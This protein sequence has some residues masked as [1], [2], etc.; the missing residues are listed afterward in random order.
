M[1]KSLKDV[2]WKEFK[3]SKLCKIYH[4]KRLTKS[5]R[6]AGKTPL[7]TASEN[8]QGVSDFICNNKLEKYQNIITID[9]FGHAFYHN[10]IC[11]GD[12]NIYFFENKNLSPFVMKF[13]TTCINQNSLKY[14]YGKQFRQGNADRDLVMLP[15]TSVGEPDYEFME[16]YIKEREKK[17]KEQYKD[18]IQ[19]R[20]AKLQ[21]KVETKK[22]WKE[23]KLKEI[24]DIEKGNQNKM[25]SL[26][27]GDIPLVSAKKFDNGYKNFVKPNNKKIFHGNCIS[28]NNDGDGGAGI[29]YY[30]PYK[31]LLDT[32]C[33]ALTSKIK[34]DK[35]AQLFL[36]EAITKQRIK[37]GHGYA[38]NSNRLKIFKI[39]L[40]ITLD[41]EPDYEYMEDYMKYLEQQKLLEYLD[42]INNVVCVS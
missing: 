3:L 11:H 27:K 19:N 37:F 23:F 1:S 5:N 16:E 18:Y 32:H 13:I 6:K 9:M 35:Y 28:L 29:A 24:F 20:I 34:L 42:Y 39:M 17:L 33:T 41:G 21:K 2:E 4:G 31:M 12:D 26:I 36:S 14:S 10:Y 40:P 25:N 15:I 30:Q 8:N 7:L 38:I 22:E